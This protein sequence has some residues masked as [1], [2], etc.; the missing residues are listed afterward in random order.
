MGH[1]GKQVYVYV[2]WGKA[3]TLSTIRP[4]KLPLCWVFLE[5]A[6]L[7]S[8][9]HFVGYN[10][11]PTNKL[12]LVAKSSQKASVTLTETHGYLDSLSL[13]TYSSQNTKENLCGWFTSTLFL[14]FHSQDQMRHSH[15]SVS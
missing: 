13:S 7:S 12:L 6:C 11:S 5:A 3:N 10:R 15:D 14:S 4:I 9:V 8:P 1:L 2:V